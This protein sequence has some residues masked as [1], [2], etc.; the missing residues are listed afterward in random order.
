MKNSN[1]IH[2]PQ[3][4]PRPMFLIQD[5]LVELTGRSKRS[6]QETTL[7][8]M[9]IEHKVRADGRLIV[10]RL[11]VEQILGVA[12]VTLRDDRDID[13]NWSAA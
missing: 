5:E 6:A 8:M 7:R 11:H 3:T 2:I 10:S 1:A 9:G 13:A 4:L 12:C